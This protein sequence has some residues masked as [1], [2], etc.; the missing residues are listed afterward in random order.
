ML[1]NAGGMWVELNPEGARINAE[2]SYFMLD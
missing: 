2:D 1:K